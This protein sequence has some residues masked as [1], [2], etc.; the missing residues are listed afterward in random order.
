MARDIGRQRYI[1]LRRPPLHVEKCRVR[2]GKIIARSKGMATE[3]FVSSRRTCV[4]I[5][6]V[7][8]PQ[9]NLISISSCL[10]GVTGIDFLGRLL[11]ALRSHL[12]WRILARHAARAQ[13]LALHVLFGEIRLAAVDLFFWHRI[14][15]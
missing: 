2:D 1:R 9:K 7:S 12:R 4:P 5:A 8:G 13:L 15:H 6:Q 3:I 11:V 14:L 10:G